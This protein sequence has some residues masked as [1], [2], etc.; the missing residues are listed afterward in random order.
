[1]HLQ[2]RG[3]GSQIR[4][5][6]TGARANSQRN[7]FVVSKISVFGKTKPTHRR[8]TSLPRGTEDVT[9]LKR[10]TVE[11]LSFWCPRLRFLQNRISESKGWKNNLF[12][13]DFLLR[14]TQDVEPDFSAHSDPP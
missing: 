13:S 9:S 10:A 2:I 12:K 8:S 3:D 1:M 11:T 5:G 6:K 14:V 4:Q 7:E